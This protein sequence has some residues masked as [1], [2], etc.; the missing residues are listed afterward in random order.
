MMD[1]RR[2]G[3]VATALVGSAA[4]LT[5]AA[6]SDNGDT[7]ADGEITLVVETFGNFG[8]EA[9]IE[10]YM[11]ENPD[12]TVEE[13]VHNELADWNETLTQ[14]I[15]AGSGL[16][17]VVGIEEGIILDVKQSADAFHD[18]NEFGAGDME[19]QFLPWKWELG[20]TDDGSLLGLGTDIGGM[21]TCYRVDHY[22][23]AGLPTDPEE[24]SALWDTWE[25]FIDV[26]VDFRDSGVDAAF[27][28]TVTEFGNAI[29][30]QHGDDIYFN[31]AGD[32]YIEESEAVEYS[33]DISEQ[34]IEE[35]LTAELEM[36]SDDWTAAIQA[37]TFATM[38][39]PAWMLGQIQENAGDDGEGLWNVADVPGEGGNWG[40]SWLGVPT[41]TE[42]PEEAADLAMFLT[43]EEG[44]L[45]AF[46]EANTL[47]SRPAVLESEEVLAMTNEYFNDAPVGEIFAAGAQDLAPVYLGAGH[48]PVQDA[49]NDQLRAWQNGEIDRDEAWAN[50]V[51]EAER[52][53]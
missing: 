44:Q 38:P 5:A 1:I 47:P 43:G 49:T 30:R 19:S 50:A 41:H 40:G 45:G 12:I 31:E 27:V 6:C 26:G 34:L 39:C 20:V 3:R 23:D 48:F 16:G 7:G 11:E 52:A 25:D 33:W 22:E 28:D 35:D 4:L 37:G 21:A 17:D 32:L 53:G 13:R 42:H 9:L 8:Y 36:W 14:N 10:Q 51:E 29:A 2:G 15:A 18:L 46:E 24:V